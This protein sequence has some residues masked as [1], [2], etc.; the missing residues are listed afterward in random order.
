MKDYEVLVMLSDDWHDWEIVTGSQN[1]HNS[2]EDILR[3]YKPLWYTSWTGTC[4]CY[5]IITLSKWCP[6]WQSIFNTS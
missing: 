6:S 5:N 1:I 2:C 3:C 4:Y